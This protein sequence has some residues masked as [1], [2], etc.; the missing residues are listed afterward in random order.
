MDTILASIRRIL[1]EDEV[2]PMEAPKPSRGPDPGQVPPDAVPAQEDVL[3][4][5]PSMM[6]EPERIEPVLR[7]PGTAAA[8][9]EDKQDVTPEPPGRSREEPRLAAPA[10]QP[11]MAPR[12]QQAIEG[13]VAAR[14]RAAAAQSFDALHQALRQEQPPSAPTSPPL[15]RAGGPTVEDLVRDELRRLLSQWL[16]AYLPNLVEAMVRAEIEKLTRR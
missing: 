16:D 2:T 8:Q 9:A 15:L 5:G 7:K 12:E 13:L 4:L 11:P 6:V 10:P 3:V 1:N 14:T